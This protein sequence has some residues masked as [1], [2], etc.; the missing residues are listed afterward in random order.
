MSIFGN[1]AAKLLLTT[2]RANQEFAFFIVGHAAPEKT[3]REMIEWLNKN[4]PGV[5]TIALNS[6]QES[7]PI[8]DYNVIQNGPDAWLRLI[9]RSA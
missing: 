7:I 2:L 3:R 5:K 6:P 4:Y 1:E 8:A 9:A